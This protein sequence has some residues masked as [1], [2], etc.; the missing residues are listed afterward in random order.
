MSF[1]A[2]LVQRFASKNGD[3]ARHVD[4]PPRLDY[5]MPTFRSSIPAIE[6]ELRRARRY[7]RPMAALVLSPVSN[8][9]TDPNTR[10]RR[11]FGHRVPAPSEAG[12][13]QFF[14]LGALLQDT[15]REFD[16]VT[17]AAEH[18]VYALFLPETDQVQARIAGLR[19]SD[20]LAQRTDAHLRVGGASFPKDSL[21][22]QD[23]FDCA[24]DAWQQNPVF[25]PHSSDI[26]GEV[27]SAR[28]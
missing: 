21:T 23:L 7:E 20:M 22:A 17:Y 25:F 12:H 11:I 24:C 26:A 16:I 18:D 2:R 10:K 19:I 6:A 8:P 27:I 3:P 5:G 28:A 4:A 15:M 14:L 1:F 9:G 13:T